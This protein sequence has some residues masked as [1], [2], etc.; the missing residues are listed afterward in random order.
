[1]ATEGIGRIIGEDIGSMKKIILAP[2]GADLE[3]FKFSASGRQRIRK[4]LH[5]NSKAIV[6]IYSGSFIGLDVDKLI[7]ILKEVLHSNKNFYLIIRI[8]VSQ[9]T[10]FEKQKLAELISRL[11]LEKKV[12]LI[13]YSGENFSKQKETCDYFSASD[14]AFSTITEAMDFCIPVKNYEYL[15]MGLPTITKGVVKGE[16]LKKMFAE[17]KIGVVVD[18]WES[19]SKQVSHAVGHFKSFKRNYSGLRDIASKKYSRERTNEIIL[20]IVKDITEQKA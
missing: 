18:D 17:S 4:K 16:S 13:D 1:M 14:M 6:A 3:L 15:A 12:F 20:G 11:N 2:N 19:F 5:V 7:T 9:Q 8:S 10:A